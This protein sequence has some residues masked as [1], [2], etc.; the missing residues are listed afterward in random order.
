MRN[1]LSRYI[2]KV[3]VPFLFKEKD[4]LHYRPMK[5]CLPYPKVEPPE[6]NPSFD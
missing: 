1:K 3:L 5:L 6:I 4:N 2:P